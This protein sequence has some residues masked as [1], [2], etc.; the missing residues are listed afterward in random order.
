[1]DEPLV[2]RRVAVGSTNPTKVEAVRRVITAAWPGVEVTGHQ[3]PSGVPVQPLGAAQTE[4]GARQRARLALE[5]AGGA[6][7]LGIGLEGGVDPAGFLLSACCARD[8]KGRESV[9][10]SL[11]MPLPPVVV[12]AVLHG[13]ELG[14]LLE[15]LGGVAGIGRGPGAVGLFT[16]GLVDR[17]QLWQMA[18]AGALAPW[19]T[20]Q[21]D[22]FSSPAG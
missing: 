7:D 12:R 11:R 20:P 2:P 15:R 9:A 4:A 14:P 10:W 19:L 17:T 16:R 18:V 3:V 13:E 8:R 6:A 1:M 21:W 22:W 5:S